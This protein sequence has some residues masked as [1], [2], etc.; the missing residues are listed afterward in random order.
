MPI[1]ESQD[2]LGPL[3]QTTS[4]AALLLNALTAVDPED[5][6]TADT[7]QVA[8]TNYLSGLKPD[9]LQGARIAVSN[10]TNAQY[11]AA[12]TALESLGATIVPITIPNFSTAQSLQTR[13]FRRDLNHYLS[14][15]PASAPIKSYDEAY[16]YFHNH[17]E[18][19]L[20]YGDSRF[21]P[22]AQFHLEKRGRARRVRG[23]QELRDRAGAHV[24][25]GLLGNGVD[26]VLQP[27]SG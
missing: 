2:T 15:L 11:V 16:A 6:H 22:P 13:E 20:K 10:S 25:D 12:R 14:R 27:S 18:E 4:D 21:G 24:P 7:A 26:A 5:P 8:G 3:V 17:P 1:R 23:R 19:G 9:A